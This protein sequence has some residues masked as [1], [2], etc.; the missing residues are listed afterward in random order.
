[1]DRDDFIR[2]I[3]RTRRNQVAATT[4]SLIDDSVGT[5]SS[6]EDSRTSFP[7]EE[8]GGLLC[9]LGALGLLATCTLELA[10]ASVTWRGTNND[11]YFTSLSTP[12][13]SKNN[14][15]GANFFLFNGTG[16]FHKSKIYSKSSNAK[17]SKKVHLSETKQGSQNGS[18]GQHQPDLNPL[19][20]LSNGHRAFA[21]DR[22]RSGYCI[23]TKT[24]HSLRPGVTLPCESLPLSFEPLPHPFS[25]TSRLSPGDAAVI[26]SPARL[27][28]PVL[29]FALLSI[30]AVPCPSNPLSTRSELSRQVHLIR[31]K[32][33]FAI[34][35][36][37]PNLPDSLLTVFIDS[38]RFQSLLHSP[39][40][41]LPPLPEVRQSDTSAILYS[42]GTT[43]RVKGVVLSHRNFIALLAVLHSRTLE[44]ET[45]AVGLFTIPLFHVFGFFMLLRTA[46]SGQT[47]VLMERFDFSA[48][49]R[50]VEKYRV[51]YMP[52]SPPLLVAMLKSDEACRSDLSSLES[53][54]CG[55][56]PLAA[57]FWNVSALTSL[58]PNNPDGSWNNVIFFL[59]KGYGLTESTG[60]V[61]SPEETDV[62]GSVGRIS[63]NI[64]ARIVNPDSGRRCLQAIGVSSGFVGQ[65]L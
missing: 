15:D 42:S 65:P 13:S 23:A 36:A 51:N 30:G 37:A 35:A 33:A 38:S 2:L 14:T 21:R 63:P 27:Q 12:S 17:I 58:H 44:R 32:I 61:T 49:I 47:A 43:G 9:P 41:P 50:A 54:A 11:S 4:Y 22:P 39:N 64:E 59:L 7:L 57:R 26:L 20:T 8:G 6:L 31:P 10:P 34:S 28:I 48:M 40:S 18:K 55:G 3:D 53:L 29:Y 1:M 5:I 52:V 45:P 24:F 25:P 16:S 62:L 19:H 46:A 60:G 56:A